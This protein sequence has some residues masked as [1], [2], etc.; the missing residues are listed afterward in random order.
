MNTPTPNQ[1]T[2]PLAQNSKLE[3]NALDTY[4]TEKQCFQHC[5]TL[6]LISNLENDASECGKAISS[7]N[8][9]KNTD[10]RKN[11]WTQI[12]PK[13]CCKFI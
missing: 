8:I 2:N 10:V 12:S 9:D 13:S 1:S 6:G 5:L 4:L 7:K 11:I 3:N